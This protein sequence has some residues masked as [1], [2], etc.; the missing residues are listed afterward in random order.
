[1]GNANRAG[2]EQSVNRF[3]SCTT[4]QWPLVVRD[5]TR[6]RRH[7]TLRRTTHRSRAGLLALRC[8]VTIFEGGEQTQIV[9]SLP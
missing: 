2:K 9:L 5:K 3:Y 6:G 4:G 7:R 8:C 1:M